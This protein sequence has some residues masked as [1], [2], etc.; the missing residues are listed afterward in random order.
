MGEKK[1]I[2]SEVT[3]QLS[4]CSECMCV[5]E[6]KHTLTRVCYGLISASADTR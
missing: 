6:F 5:S 1:K 3:R 4:V 2:N